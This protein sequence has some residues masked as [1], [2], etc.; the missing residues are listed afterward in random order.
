MEAV[1]I[2]AFG[3]VCMACFVMGAKV[4]QS[5]AKGEPIETPTVNPVKAIKEHR[6]RQE[7]EME[8]SRMETI[9]QNIDNYDGTSHKQEDVPKR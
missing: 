4:G 9:L 7:T 8:Q 3:F 2:L 6:A 5:V 1:T